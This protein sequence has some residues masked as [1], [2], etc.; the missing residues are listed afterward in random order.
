MQVLQQELFSPLLPLVPRES[1][2]EAIDYVNAHA[3]P[4]ALYY[5]GRSAIEQR[6]VLDRTIAGGVSVNEITYHYGI[7]DLP[8]GGVG[9]SGMGRYPGF[10][11]FREFS[12]A[13]AIYRHGWLD[14]SAIAGMRPPYGARLQRTLGRELRHWRKSR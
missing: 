7:D 14:T 1:V 11:G 12:H 13:K 2:A 3:R 6:E 5:F 9:P 4:L 10:D 8:F